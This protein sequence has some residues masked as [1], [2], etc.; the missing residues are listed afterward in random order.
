MPLAMELH[1]HLK[2][3]EAKH[4]KLNSSRIKIVIIT[5]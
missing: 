3:T 1:Q 2:N 4:G 5:K